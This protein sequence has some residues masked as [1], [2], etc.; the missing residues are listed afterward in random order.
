MFAQ[1]TGAAMDSIAPWH[2]VACAWVAQ[3]IRAASDWIWDLPLLVIV[4]GGGLF[5]LLRSGLGPFRHLGHAVAVLAGRHDRPGAAGEVSHY[6]ALS[7]ALAATVGMGNISGVAVAIAM[8]GPGA[9]FWMW[10]AAIVGTA[11][12]YFECTLAVMYRGR[13]SLGQLQGGPMYVITEGLG[14]RW[15]PLAVWFSLAGLFGCLPIFNANQLTRAIADIAVAPGAPERAASAHPWIGAALAL[16]TAVVIFGGLVRIGRVVSLL[17]PFMVVVYFVLVTGIL[18]EHARALPGLFGAIVQDAFHPTHYRGEAMFGGALGGLIV[19]GARRASFSNEAGLGTAAMAHGA[20][21]T[22]EPVH[23]GLVAMLG[24]IIDTLFVCTLTA[25]ALLATGVHETVQ[26]S[27]VA[28]TL[29]AFQ[30]V[31]PRFGGELLLV[32]IACFSLSSLFTY[33]YFG[34]KCFGFVFGAQRAGLYRWLYIA[35]IGAG[36]VASL[37][38]TISFI[39]LMFALMAIPTILSAVLLSNAVMRETRRYWDARRAGAGR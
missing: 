12:K 4:M 5:F 23:E 18:V 3:S 27:G 7:V 38:T 30:E 1:G 15:R 33:A 39:D 17:V 22:D 11:T 26:G 24:P 37:D 14:P 16:L 29:A 13:D 36:A 25:L 8:G 32:C 20:A 10:I 31:Y 34:G 2:E 21:R 9:I 28:L 35:S 6:Q 19:L